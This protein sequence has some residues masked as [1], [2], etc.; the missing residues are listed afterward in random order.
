MPMDRLHFASLA[1]AIESAE[2]VP[3]EFDLHRRRIVFTRIGRDEL[4]RAAFA[5]RGFGPEMP[6]VFANVD[7]VLAY[8]DDV[9]S[10]AKPVRFIFISAFCCSTLLAR[11]LD[12]CSGCVVIREP[13][14]LGQ[15]ALAK[16]RSPRYGCPGGDQRDADWQELVHLALDL[17]ARG[18]RT[19][20]AVILK[21]ADSCNALIDT[22]SAG[23]NEAQQILLYV[24]MRVFIL[25]VLKS[26]QRR[27]W[28]RA[29]VRLW[30]PSMRSGTPLG[31]LRPDVMDDA[32]GAA[33]L[34]AV[35]AHLWAQALGRW[36]AN[37]FRLLNGDVVAQD[38]ATALII[39]GDCFHLGLGPEDIEGAIK[40]SG[41]RDRHA[42][43]SR[44]YGSSRR[45]QDLQRWEGQFGLAADRAFS[46]MCQEIPEF[47]AISRWL[48]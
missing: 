36:G 1:E 32:L 6:S 27:E 15:L 24:G 3:T 26:E 8:N 47:E 30:R 29:R 43:S 13:P 45:S 5:P 17:L 37:R 41:T 34:W 33:Y 11:F 23:P 19:E 10:S 28:M 21:L 40:G 38:P 4:R 42:K 46:R 2:Y 12:H 39:A 31:G 14:I 20:R 16:L 44:A 48:H 35:T 9:K 25:S 7:D 18:A 22:I